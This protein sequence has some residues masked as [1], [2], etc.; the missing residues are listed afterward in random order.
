[1]DCPTS[2]GRLALPPKILFEVYT[3]LCDGL[4]TDLPDDMRRF[5]MVFLPKGTKQHDEGPMLTRD[6]AAT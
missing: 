3:S 4:V 1:M 5:P 2:A 6:C